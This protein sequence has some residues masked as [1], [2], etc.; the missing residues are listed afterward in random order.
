ME[1]LSLDQTKYAI[2]KINRQQE[3]L[4]E[5][6]K[7]AQRACDEL[8]SFALNTICMDILEICNEIND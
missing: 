7:L 3:C 1:R 2:S 4:E 8:D 5:I 6:K